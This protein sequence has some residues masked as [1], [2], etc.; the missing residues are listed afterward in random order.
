MALPWAVLKGM[1]FASGERLAIAPHSV[2]RTDSGPVRAGDAATL[3][4]ERAT[5]RRAICAWLLT[6]AAPAPLIAV[7]YV[8]DEQISVTL[9]VMTSAI[10]LGAAVPMIAVSLGWTWKRGV[11]FW[12][13]LLIGGAVLTVI[14]SMLQP[15]A[16]RFA[17]AR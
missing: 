13:A 14:V 4:W 11:L 16:R 12:L 3:A 2:V 17:H 8:S 1:S 5:H 9:I 10:V 15:G 7:A 6:V